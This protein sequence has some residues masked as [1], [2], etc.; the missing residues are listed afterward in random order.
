MSFWSICKLRIVEVTTVKW[1]FRSYSKPTT[2]C[3]I[4][5]FK[6]CAST[7]RVLAKNLL[8]QEKR[9]S[10]LGWWQMHLQNRE[11]FYKGIDQVNW[12]LLFLHKNDFNHFK[13]SK[14]IFLL[15]SRVTRLLVKSLEHY[16]EGRYK[17]FLIYIESWASTD[18][19]NLKSTKQT[20]QN[21]WNAHVSCL[22]FPTVQFHFEVFTHHCD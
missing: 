16:I 19:Q 3:V 15:N 13:Q 17:V 10:L 22:F 6:H 1:L 5:N 21:W 14:E 8:N 9:G 18:L 4:F 2:N 20:S 11:S 12:Q 7:R